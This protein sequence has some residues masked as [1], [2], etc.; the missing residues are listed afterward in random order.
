MFKECNNEQTYVRSCLSLTLI[1]H[2]TPQWSQ[3]LDQISL[4]IQY[5]NRTYKLENVPKN[6]VFNPVVLKAVNT[7]NNVPHWL[8]RGEVQRAH[9]SLPT[10][11]AFRAIRSYPNLVF[12]AVILGLIDRSNRSNLIKQLACRSRA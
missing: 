1:L 6:S 11:K 2:E 4:A 10:P 3:P 5:P 9:D 8:G 12:I 7:I